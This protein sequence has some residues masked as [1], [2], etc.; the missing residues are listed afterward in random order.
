MVKKPAC[1]PWGKAFFWRVATLFIYTR[2]QVNRN[3]QIIPF[4][5]NFTFCF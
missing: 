1:F 4:P 2:Q 3:K 5:A